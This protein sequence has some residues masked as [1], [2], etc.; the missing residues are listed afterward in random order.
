[1]IPRF[2][3]PFLHFG[4]ISLPGSGFFNNGQSQKKK[5]QEKSKGVFD[6]GLG[7]CKLNGITVLR[8]ALELH[9][10]AHFLRVE[11]W[12]D[13]KRHPRV[14]DSRFYANR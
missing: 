2:A 8:T 1:M 13:F 14:R 3:K 6:K 12:I 7:F 11:Y 5:S 10:I 9:F 4:T